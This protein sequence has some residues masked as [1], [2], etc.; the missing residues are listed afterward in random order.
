[1]VLPGDRH[2]ALLH[3]LQEGRLGARTGTVDLI[4]HQ[5]LAEHRTGDEAERA[6]PA[7][8]FLEHLGAQ[9]IGGHQVGGALDALVVEPEDRAERL[10]QPRLG[11]PGHADQQRVAARQQR[12]QGLLDHLGLTEDDLADALADELEALPKRFDLGD[13]IRRSAAY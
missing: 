2:P 13:E 1:M 8:A 7:L 6:P 11:E 10:D 3:R 5:Q 12:D 9:D 4:G